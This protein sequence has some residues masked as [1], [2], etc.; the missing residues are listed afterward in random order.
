MIDYFANNE[1]GIM[2]KK[3]IMAELKVVSTHLSEGSGEF[4]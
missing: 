1:L 4:Y 2:W 3:E